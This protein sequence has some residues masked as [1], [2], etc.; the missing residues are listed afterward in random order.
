MQAA[1]SPPVYR[2]IG[3]LLGTFAVP[4]IISMVVSTLYNIVDQIFIG[5][6]VGY[7]GNGATNVILPLTVIA[8][9]LALMIGDG[10]TAYFSLCL[11]Q[12]N[13]QG[14]AQG[15]GSAI[16]LMVVVS[17]LLTVLSLLFLKPLCVLFGAT[18]ANMPYALEYGYIIALG[19]PFYLFGMG[20]NGIV[21]ADGRPVYAMLATLS[22]AILNT[23]LDP[24]FIFAF[25]MGVRGAAIAT[26]L[27]QIVSCVMTLI[28]LKRF[29]SIALTR[30]HLRPRRKLYRKVCSLGISSFSLQLAGTIVIIAMNNVL[31]QYGADSKYGAEIPMT[32]LGITM[33]VSQIITGIVIGISVGSQPI[34]GYNY[35]AGK[36]ARAQKTYLLA[37]V[38]STIVMGAGTLLFQGF[39]DKIVGIFG[40]ESALYQEFAV[41]SL[42]IFLLLILLNGFQMCT[43]TFFQAIGKP[44]QATLISLS[45]QVLFL[46]PA[47][48]I[49]PRFLGVEGALWAGPVG[50]ACAFFLA[51]A[52]ALVEWRKANRSTRKAT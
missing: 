49:L 18:D 30:E 47:L 37:I 27:G 4:S 15:V 14:A 41:K 21:R 45:R 44:V 32:T 3:K 12:G 46:L 7:L 48:L 39:P 1:T 8:L 24:V 31:V 34:I 29:R 38:C 11:G 43:G 25:H 20:F 51:L 13:R 28:A 35:G 52:F 16:T 26:V 9:A 36:I 40:A 23:I 10:T 2:P 22:G 50:D 6:G 42:K 5:R 19:F 33:K 17:I